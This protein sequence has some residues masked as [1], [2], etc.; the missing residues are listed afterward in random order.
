M[1]TK[2]VVIEIGFEVTDEKAFRALGAKL[3]KEKRGQTAKATDSLEQVAMD[4]LF[5]SVYQVDRATLVA[6]I[7]ED[8]EYD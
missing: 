1:S 5:G 3:L 6:D 4:I 8:R 7:P 2:V